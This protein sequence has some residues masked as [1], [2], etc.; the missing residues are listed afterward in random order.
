[1]VVELRGALLLGVTTAD[2]APLMIG[3]GLGRA[4]ARPPGEI[5]VGVLLR[6]LVGYGSPAV[7]DP[8]CTCAVVAEVGVVG[9]VALAFGHGVSLRLRL[10]V[11]VGRTPAQDRGGRGYRHIL[12]RNGAGGAHAEGHEAKHYQRSRKQ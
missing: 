8:H 5:L 4:P 12:L 10:G 3:L 9:V 11:S 7:V 1:M 2:L 6:L